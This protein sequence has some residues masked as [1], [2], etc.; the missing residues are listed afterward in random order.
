MDGDMSVCQSV[1]LLV[2]RCPYA[3]FYIHMSVSRS[4]CLLVHLYACHYVCMS[5]HA[6]IPILRL[7]LT[8]F[9]VYCSYTHSDSVLL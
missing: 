8:F 4:T 9:H 6:L 5:I 1:C 7:L 3:Y 2:F